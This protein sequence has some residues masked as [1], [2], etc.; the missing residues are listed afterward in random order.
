MSKFPSR[1]QCFIFWITRLL[2]DSSLG[3]ISRNIRS[4]I[5]GMGKD[6]RYGSCRNTNGKEMKMIQTL[7]TTNMF[8]F[9][10]M[11]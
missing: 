6:T 3:A 2:E 8:S 4:H 9:D 11:I 5:H 10:E 7:P 1:R